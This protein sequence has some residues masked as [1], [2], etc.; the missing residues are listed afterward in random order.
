LTLHLSNWYSKNMSEKT[1]QLDNSTPPAKRKQKPKT[2]KVG[3]KR[4]TLVYSEH[5]D[6]IREVFATAGLNNEVTRTFTFKKPAKEGGTYTEDLPI[7]ITKVNY[8]THRGFNSYIGDKVM[9]FMPTEA[10]EPVDNTFNTPEGIDELVSILNDIVD[11]Y[12]TNPM[13]IYGDSYGVNA[14]KLYTHLHKRG[15]RIRQGD[16]TKY[17]K[18]ISQVSRNEQ[19]M[20]VRNFNPTRADITKV[21]TIIAK[22]ARRKR[23]SNGGK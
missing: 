9:V 14:S 6:V 12:F 13:L 19:G 7:R 17:L 23:V 11:T 20:D 22:H 3:S 1:K 10:L 2:K 15:V 21:A 16:I 4:V 8:G 18:L 5:E